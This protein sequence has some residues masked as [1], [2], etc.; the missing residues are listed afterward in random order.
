MATIKTISG[1]PRYVIES[2]QIKTFQ[3]P[4]VL[5]LMRDTNCGLSFCEWNMK[6]IFSYED[7]VV[8]DYFGGV[9][10]RFDGSRFQTP[11]YRT[12]Y[13]LDRGWV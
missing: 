5:Y 7:G 10:Y 12:M 13:W 9:L 1:Q 3:S 2:G 8:R 6:R 4:L 11:S